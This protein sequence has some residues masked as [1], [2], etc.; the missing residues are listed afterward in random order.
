MKEQQESTTKSQAD[1]S[2]AA[3]LRELAVSAQELL[4][5]EVG[6][7]K[8]ELADSVS[9]AGRHIALTALFGALVA[10]S[11]L[12][13]IAFLVIA[14]GD[15]LDGRYWLSS[16]IT[17]CAFAAIGGPLAWRAYIRLT[18]EDFTLPRTRQ[19]LDRNAIAVQSR[20][21]DLKNMSTGESHENTQLH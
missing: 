12:P 1:V 18:T 14:L 7:V 6:L 10:L 11:L 5:N 9:R 15:Y 2:Y 8:A 20:V 16:L 17:A 19:S 3:A 21:E 4:H 13:L